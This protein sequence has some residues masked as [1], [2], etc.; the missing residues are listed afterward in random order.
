MTTSRGVGE[1]A[2]LVIL[3]GQL[4][5]GSQLVVQSQRNHPALE[6]IKLLQFNTTWRMK[7]SAVDSGFYSTLIQIV[8]TMSWILTPSVMRVPRLW[9]VKVIHAYS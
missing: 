2:G 7:L 6:T 4:S 8:Q 9:D 5:V 3:L 1:V